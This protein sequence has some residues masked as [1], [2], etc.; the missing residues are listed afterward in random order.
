MLKRVDTMLSATLHYCVHLKFPFALTLSLALTHIRLW[1]AATSASTLE[2]VYGNLI[3]EERSAVVMVPCVESRRTPL[4]CVSVFYKEI[5]RRNCMIARTREKACLG[6]RLLEWLKELRWQAKSMFVYGR[7][8]CVC[9]L[10]S[11]V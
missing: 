4:Y 11:L 3:T 6:T 8:L 7:S 10:V 2:T 1:R 5:S 9:S